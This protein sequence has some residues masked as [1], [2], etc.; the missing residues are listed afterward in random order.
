MKT[1][2]RWAIA[3]AVAYVGGVALAY[4]LM[5]RTMRNDHEADFGGDDT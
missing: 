1:V 3:A 2:A 5:A 4:V